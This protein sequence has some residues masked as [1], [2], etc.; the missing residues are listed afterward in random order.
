MSSNWLL[1]VA[2][3]GTVYRGWQRQ[4]DAGTVQGELEQALTDLFGC[5]PQG[6][7]L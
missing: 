4:R 1:Q 2:Y 7:R 5:D 6:V 3:D